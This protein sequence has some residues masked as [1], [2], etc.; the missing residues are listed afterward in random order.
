[1]VKMMIYV[2]ARA[3]QCLVVAV[4]LIVSLIER[5]HELRKNKRITGCAE[6][7]GTY[8]YYR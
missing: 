6:E 1:M 8:Q 4:G 2:L 5:L 7:H 3:N